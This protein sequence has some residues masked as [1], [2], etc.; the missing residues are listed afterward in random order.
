MAYLFSIRIPEPRQVKRWLQHRVQKL[1]KGYSDDETWDLDYTLAEFLLPRLKRFKQL[2]TGHPMGMTEA[3][4]EQYLD[5]M[6]W[7]LQFHQDEKNADWLKIHGKDEPPPIEL[8][9]RANRGLELI[10]RHWRDLW[11]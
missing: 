6:I 4:W 8:H 3:E 5:D 11:W 2:N 7:A 1:T 9:E 10:G